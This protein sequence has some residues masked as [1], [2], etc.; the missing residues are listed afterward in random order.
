[1]ALRQKGPDLWSRLSALGTATLVNDC[2][3]EQTFVIEQFL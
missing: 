2:V 3:D 1:M